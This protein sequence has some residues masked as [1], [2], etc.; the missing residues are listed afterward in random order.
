M[1]NRA[2]YIDHDH[3]YVY[4]DAAVFDGHAQMQLCFPMPKNSYDKYDD[5]LGFILVFIIIF[6][7]GFLIRGS[8][9]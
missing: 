2:F 4:C 1:K 3:E 7:L 6:G 8:R 9:K 5:I